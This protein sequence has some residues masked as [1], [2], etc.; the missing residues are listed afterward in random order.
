M[1]EPL[2][3]QFQPNDCIFDRSLLDS[4]PIITCS[5]KRSGLVAK[6]LTDITFCSSKN[7]WYYGLKLYVIGFCRPNRLPIPEQMLIKPASV[8][9]LTVFKEAWGNIVNRCFVG[10]KI[11]FDQDYFPKLAEEKTQ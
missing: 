9:D 7:L 2:L 10:D 11:Y 5:G 8:S 4:M 3:S 6:E 1:I